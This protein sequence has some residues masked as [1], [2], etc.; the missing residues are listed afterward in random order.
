ML[1]K[2]N[3]NMEEKMKY[4]YEGLNEKSK[5]RY[6]AV[7]A[8]KLGHGGIKYISEVLGISPKTISTGKRELEELKKTKMMEKE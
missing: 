2:Y 3:K 1:Q 7:E 8:Q 6:A 4:V 5:R